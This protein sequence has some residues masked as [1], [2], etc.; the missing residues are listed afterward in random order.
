MKHELA[1]DPKYSF[2]MRKFGDVTLNL[3]TLDSVEESF[4]PF[5]DGEFVGICDH[6]QY[7]YPDYFGYQPEYERKILKMCE[8]MTNAGYTFVN[9][10]EILN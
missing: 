6:E 8:I 9:G 7:F 4:K 1:K 10:D 2:G 3:E 5:L